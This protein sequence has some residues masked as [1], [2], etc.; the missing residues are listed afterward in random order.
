MPKLPWSIRTLYADRFSQ[1][2]KIAKLGKLNNTIVFN[3]G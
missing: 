2:G 3:R 1:I